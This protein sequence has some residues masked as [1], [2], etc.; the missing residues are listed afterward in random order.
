MKIKGIIITVVAISIGCNIAMS[1]GIPTAI[2]YGNGY[3]PDTKNQTATIIN[4]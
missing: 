4:M 2:K 3:S 1:T